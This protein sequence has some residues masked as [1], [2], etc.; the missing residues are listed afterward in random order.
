MTEDL[1]KTLEEIKVRIGALEEEIRRQRQIQENK[2]SLAPR[3]VESSPNVR[4][5]GQMIED[6]INHFHL[7]PEG[8]LIYVMGYFDQVLLNK[9]EPIAQKVKI[10]SPIKTPL[11]KKNEDALK[12]LSKAGTEVRLHPMLHARVFCVPKQ[13][14]LIVGSGDIQTDCFGGSRYDAGIM[15]NYPQAII[16]AMKF[17]DK[18]WEESIPFP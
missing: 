7:A 8:N 17:F 16:D 9:L 18:V 1:T 6:L 11:S 5:Y 15:S 13:N 14:F 2:E 10:I 3:F 4:T 12:R